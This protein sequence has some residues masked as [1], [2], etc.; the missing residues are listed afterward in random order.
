MKLA[1]LVLIVL[2][3]VLLWK[4]RPSDAPRPST[5]TPKDDPEPQDM[6]RCALCSVHVP[7]ADAAQGQHGVYCSPEHRHHAEP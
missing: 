7:V 5:P 3:G 1:L 4:S 2:I 6:V